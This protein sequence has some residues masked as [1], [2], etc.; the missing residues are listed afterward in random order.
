VTCVDSSQKAIDQISYNAALNQVSNVN[1]ICADA[2]EYLK[3]KTDEQFDVV[4]LDPPALIQKRR[5][6]EQGRQAYFVLN[7]QALKRTKDGGILISA[8][9]SLHMTT[10]DLLNIV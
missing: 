4:V 9:C 6:F 5:D 7:E 3:I 8:S 10:E 2:F 1:A